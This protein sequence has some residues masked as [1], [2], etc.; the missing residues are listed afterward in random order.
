MPSHGAATS[1]S[2]RIEFS[3][4]RLRFAQR[5]RSW[6]WR[7]LGIVKALLSPHV[8]VDMSNWDPGYRCRELQPENRMVRD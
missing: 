5:C 3:V 2:P 6:L 7:A 8:L 4:Q 1:V